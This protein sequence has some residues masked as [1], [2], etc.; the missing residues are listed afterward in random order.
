M[1]V[2]SILKSCV[3]VSLFA[4][5]TCSF[6]DSADN[7]INNSIISKLSADQ[8]L[9][10]TNIS[11]KTD[12]GIVSL[13]GNVDSDT[14][15][16]AA[17]QIAQSTLH[18][19]DVHTNDL[20]IKGSQHIVADTIISA[21]VRGMFIQKKLFGDKDVAAISINIETNNGT[22]SLSGTADNKKEIDNAI[23]IAK[24]VSGVKSVNSSVTVVPVTQ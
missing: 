2:L 22:V 21:K 17:T 6:A 9:A 20:T 7:N 4:F 18:V 19:K 5:A 24:S 15:A 8:S 23:I 3:V 11:V 10:G 12:Q 14:Q 1:R 13:T 16:A